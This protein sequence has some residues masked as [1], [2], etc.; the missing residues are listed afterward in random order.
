[1]NDREHS[2]RQS[3]PSNRRDWLRGAALAVLGGGSGW[4]IWNSQRRDGAA[5]AG[6]GAPT[7]W[8]WQLDPNKCIACGNCATYCVLDESAVK[9]VHNHPMCGYCELCTGFFEPDPMNLDAGAENQL[10]PTGAILRQFVEDPYFEYHIEESLCIGCGKCVK[11]CSTFG[12][13]SLYLQV[14]HDRCLNCN[15]CAIAVACPSDAFQ[16]V[17]T[18]RP[19]L[20]KNRP[21][22]A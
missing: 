13:G 21:E 1:M 9:C 2:D 15:E 6:Q 12:N 17:P 14:L 16:R 7:E 4:L 8:L 22:T 5:T 20:H 18:D 19:Y 3:P 10:C 11:G